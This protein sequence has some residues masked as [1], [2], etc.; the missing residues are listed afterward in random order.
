MT[1]PETPAPESLVTASPESGAGSEP[2]AAEP[3]VL[4]GTPVAP[5]LG[6]GPARI[7]SEDLAEVTD[8]RVPQEKVQGELERFRRGLEVV[9]AELRE[10]AGN[11]GGKVPEGHVRILD[12]HV[13]VLR[14]AVFLS[15]VENLVL[16]EQL[17][18]EAAIAKVILDFDRIFK[19]VENEAIRERAVDLR[20]VGIRVLRALEREAKDV[21]LETPEPSLDPIE[22][23]VLV[24]RELTVVDLMDPT[25]A[26]PAAIVTESGTSTSHA[27]VL[28]RSLGIP[29]LCG[30]E[31]LL[32]HVKA[33]EFV[34]VDAA[35]GVARIRPEPRIIEQFEAVGL[36][37]AEPAETP[38]WLAS[39]PR[40]LDGT[41]PTLTAAC[42]SLP[43]VQSMR[44]LGIEGIGMYRTEL[45]YLLDREPP[46]VDALIAHYRAVLAE[47][48]PVRV[49]FRLAD[50]SAG[51]GVPWLSRER[52]S[53]P[54][55]GRAGVRLLLDRPEL[56]RRQLNALLCAADGHP[57][58]V[59]LAVPMVVDCGEFRRIREALFEERYAL[60]RE[61]IPH[62]A[63]LVL[64]A[65]IETPAAVFGARDLA[66]EA[67]FLAIG[68]DSFQQ[69][70]LAAD[71]GLPAHGV[72]FEHLHPYVLRAVAQVVEAAEAA[73]TP[74]RVFGITA[75][76]PENVGWL[77]GVGVR[78]LVVGL[79]GF[80]N[81]VR[82]IRAT[83][84]QAAR[85][86]AEARLS[87]VSNDERSPIGG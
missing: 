18:L 3:V 41:T 62:A 53:N 5:G 7:A 11:L 85:R 44:G 75:A 58:E 48:G 4:R 1:A 63:D 12:T 21:A 10:L 33:G 72:H 61:N 65:V 30:A 38:E 71:R 51:L 57:A 77:L 84:I 49:T 29:T 43:D 56:L 2:V 86:S 9:E 26:R 37:G 76:R 36:P 69:Y 82:A 79:A 87:D 39:A 14:D 16:R 46:T 59:G 60:R 54:A 17:A 73:G 31:G 64:G 66:A 35:E 67:A 19:L 68:L 25:G 83:E 20:D 27:A 28:A 15:D 6:M 52:E 78:D 34:I 24:A 50:L 55:L 42:G 8:R 32:S 70:I 80:E 74:L 81:A 13:T 47:A 40:T 23:C 45:L 22:G